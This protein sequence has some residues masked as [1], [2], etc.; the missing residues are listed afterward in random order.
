ML[1]YSVHI[2][3]AAFNSKKQTIKH[4][5]HCKGKKQFFLSKTQDF[6][7][8]KQGP[9]YLNP[10]TVFSVIKWGGGI[11]VKTK[12]GKLNKQTNNPHK[13]NKKKT[14]QKT[15]NPNQKQTSKCCTIH[16][17]KYKR[18]KSFPQNSGKECHNT[19]PMSP[20]AFQSISVQPSVMYFGLTTIQS[21]QAQSSYLAHREETLLPNRNTAPQ[22]LRKGTL[23]VLYIAALLTYQETPPYHCSWVPICPAAILWVTALKA[24]ISFPSPSAHQPSAFSAPGI[25]LLA[26]SASLDVLR[27]QQI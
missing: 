6:Q 18:E 1:N 20:T 14:T 19:P 11:T 10:V 15:L 27:V 24:W 5:K 9:F 8:E 2:S 23:P 12:T 22:P 4:Q 17:I 16:F 13:T 7:T 25:A 3:Y 21:L 26:D